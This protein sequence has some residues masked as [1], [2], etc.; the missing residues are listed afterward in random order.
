MAKRKLTSE[1][2]RLVEKN[3]GLVAVHLRRLLSPGDEPRRDREWEDLFQEGCFGLAG[4]AMTYD[5]RC[6][7]PFAAY[8]LRRIKMV[9][10]RAL[11]RA[12]ATVHVPDGERSSDQGRHKVVSLRGDPPI[13]KPADRQRPWS[14]DPPETIGDRVRSKYTQAVLDAKNAICGNPREDRADMTERLATERWLVPA[15]EHRTRLRQIVRDTGSTYSRVTC[16]EQ[17]MIAHIRDRLGNDAEFNELL[18]QARRSRWGMDTALDDEA[19][20]RLSATLDARIGRMFQ[21][22][23]ED[24]RALMLMHILRHSGIT[25]EDRIRSLVRRLTIDQKNA[26]LARCTSIAERQPSA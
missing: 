26:C 17:R 23:P 18:S 9:V 5:P 14:D 16:A 24:R 10:S 4:A 6:G 25:V 3:L 15:E 20:E 22:A 13:R 2:R 8:A 12:F 19:L 21:N 1:Q 11:S 7:V